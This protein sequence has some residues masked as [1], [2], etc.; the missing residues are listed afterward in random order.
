MPAHSQVVVAAP[1]GHLGALPPGDGVILC[2]R[3]DLSAPV[4]GLEDSV[5]VVLLF[6]SNLLSE[7]A[8]VVVAGANCRGESLT[9][10]S[11]TAFKELRKTN[12][13]LT[14]KRTHIVFEEVGDGV[15]LS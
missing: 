11:V 9:Y 10:G 3:E 1:D 12:Y 8:V 15:S 13:I 14:V 5:C 7:E 4:H 2:K 6:L